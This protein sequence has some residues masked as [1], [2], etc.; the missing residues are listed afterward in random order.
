M[1][2][3][4]RIEADTDIADPRELARHLMIA[5]ARFAA[6]SMQTYGGAYPE[7]ATMLM[8]SGGSFGVRVTD[9]LSQNPRVALVNMIGGEE[10]EIA[11][12]VLQQ[13]APLNPLRMN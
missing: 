1:T 12:V 3:E 4:T 13:P 8:Q 6:A 5:A 10:V 9:L 7:Q 2:N 11:H